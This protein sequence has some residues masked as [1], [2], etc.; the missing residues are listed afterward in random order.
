MVVDS[1]GK[2]GVNIL[3]PDAQ[4]HITSAA[5]ATKGL[6][7]RGAA[8]QSANLQE[9]LNSAGTTASAVKSDGSIQPA[10]LADSAA[11]NNS[12]YYSTTASKLVYKDSGGTVNNLY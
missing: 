5:A 10:S 11:T 9:W 2:I 12:I 8:A 1:S 6:I 7:V 3:T 4:V